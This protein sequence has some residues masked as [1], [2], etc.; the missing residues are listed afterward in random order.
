MRIV[1]Q[2]VNPERAHQLLATQIHNR[3]LNKK[4]VAEL[5][6]A[7]SHDMWTESPD[8]VCIDK[9]GRLINGQHRLN[10]I[11]QANK[12]VLLTIAYD[13]PTDAVI[14]RGLERSV[15]DSEYMRGLIP[16][17]LSSG[18]IQ[19]VITR[20]LSIASPSE[21]DRCPEDI[22]VKFS[23]ENRDNILA[24]VTISKCGASRNIARR[25]CVKAS[26]QAAILAALISGVS[27]TAL[28][29]FAEIV[30]TGMID[31]ASESAAIIF[32][33]WL[34]NNSDNN[35]SQSIATMKMAQTAI[36][37]FVD[38]NPRRRAYTR[39]DHYYVKSIA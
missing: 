22:R 12:P 35:R 11:I 4:R 8:A 24:A 28:T 39:T 16:I 38:Q 21:G 27:Y 25:L 7:I 26:V 13:V 9:Y 17:E 20:Y 6:Y 29:R 10:A 31:G 3:R 37:D 18:Q 19:A 33:N 34:L 1:Q 5:A 14:D 30:N 2:M 15:G 23:N 36:K 32:R